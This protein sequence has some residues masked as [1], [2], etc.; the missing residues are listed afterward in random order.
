MQLLNQ[1]RNSELKNQLI[2]LSLFSLF[3]VGMSFFRF[4]Y[5]GTKTYLFLNWNLFMAFIPYI[6][7]V[8]LIISKS[9][10][11][12]WIALCSFVIFAFFPN[13]TYIITDFFHLKQKAEIPLWYDLALI[14]SF[15]WTGL[16]MGFL[17]LINLEKILLRKI[18][19][20]TTNIFMFIF[21]FLTSFGIYLGR[22]LRWNSWDIISNPF[23]LFIDVFDRFYNPIQH[24]RT[25][26][27]T[28]LFGIL[29]NLMFFTFKTL[30][31]IKNEK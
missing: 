16:F 31:V 4:Y 27:F 21:L 28:I 26:A 5:S 15:A 9:Q 24:P 17:S 11:K 8:I 30:S 22:Y 25:W 29:L 10:N 20:K 3:A 23:N 14:F 18:N 2:L 1:I 13:S 12:Y 7:A 6:F 19:E